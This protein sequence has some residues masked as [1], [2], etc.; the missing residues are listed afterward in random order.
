MNIKACLTKSW[1][2]R[3]KPTLWSVPEENMGLSQSSNRLEVFN[4]IFSIRSA[5]K[6]PCINLVRI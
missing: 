4:P 1:P 2:F 5:L 6:T 3:E